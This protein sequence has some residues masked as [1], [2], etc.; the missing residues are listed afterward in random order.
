MFAYC[1][2][3]EVHAQFLLIYCLLITEIMDTVFYLLR[4]LMRAA[5]DPVAAIF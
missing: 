1:W 4:N 3:Y 5:K 2:F